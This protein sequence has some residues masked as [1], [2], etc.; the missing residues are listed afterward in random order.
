MPVMADLGGDARTIAFVGAGG[1][2]KTS[3]TE[4]LAA[5]YARADADVVVV[6][7]RATTAAPASPRGSSRSASSVIAADTRRAGRA[8]AR[9]PR[10][11]R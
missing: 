1:A 4:R 5:A 2:G 3:A 8:P 6:A 10:G 7:L 11:R 9:P